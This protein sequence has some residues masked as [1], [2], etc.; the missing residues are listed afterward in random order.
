MRKD[1]TSKCYGG[2]ISR[3]RK[4]PVKQERG[5]KEDETVWQ[6]VH[7]RRCLHPGAEEQLTDPNG[8]EIVP[9]LL[10]GLLWPFVN[11]SGRTF[12][13]GGKMR[14]AAVNWLALA[15]KVRCYR[16]DR[17]T[18]AELAELD[19]REG[20]LRRCLR[21]ERGRR[22]AARWRIEAP[23]GD[24]LRRNGG[25]IYPK[26]SL[27]E[28]V[29]FFIVAAIVILDPQLPPFRP[30]SGKIST[31]SMWLTYYGG[32]GREPAAGVRQRLAGWY[33]FW[34]LAGLRFSAASIAPRGRQVSCS[35]C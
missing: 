27:A 26:T 14:N 29:D 32:D 16:R 10:E 2:D 24:V 33:A 18:A 12:A 28:N 8:P 21:D 23:G 19:Q 7:S 31:N 4:L 3:K 25:A 30:P 5:Q 11:I 15:A 20:E 35:T 1:V 22:E 6:S 13:G 9:Q 17:L 34:R